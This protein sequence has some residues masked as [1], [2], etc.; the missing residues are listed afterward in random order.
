MHK[1]NEYAQNSF[2]EK[3]LFVRI[4]VWD[5]RDRLSICKDTGS[6]YYTPVTSRNEKHVWTRSDTS[7]AHMH[8]SAYARLPQR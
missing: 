1:T 3:T 8:T 6:K 2:V 7:F 5:Q 4:G